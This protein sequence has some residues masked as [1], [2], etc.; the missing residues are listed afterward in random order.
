MRRPLIT[1]FITNLGVG[2]AERVVVN[3]ANS[4]IER[5][6]RVD[7]VLIRAEGALLGALVPEVNIIDLKAQS[8]GASVLPFIAYVRRSN[9]RKIIAN[10]WPL[11]IIAIVASRLFLLRRIRV[12]VVEHTSLQAATALS[13]TAVALQKKITMKLFFPLA[14]K[15]VCVSEAAAK[16]LCEFLGMDIVNLAVIYNPIV[17]EQA[18]RP[19]EDK[20]PVQWWHSQSTRLLAV[21]S[22]KAVKNF[23]RLLDATANILRSGDAQLLILGEGECRQSLAAHAQALGVADA[24]F[25]PGVVLD[26]AAYYQRADIVALTSDVEGLP[27]VLIEALAA[28]TSVVSTDCPSGPREIL[29]DGRYGKLVP[30]GPDVCVELEAQIRAVIA[31]PFDSEA[32]KRRAGCFSITAATDKYERLFNEND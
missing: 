26:T 20:Q 2:G 14:H 29:C 30:L 1:I 24:V 15:V 31:K 17:G 3:L 5:G 28:G 16:S 23:T 25:M 19:V 10:M 18:A 11:T 21:G 8:I 7:V 4:F 27:T 9:T 13:G 6:Y 12:I 32:L 22:L